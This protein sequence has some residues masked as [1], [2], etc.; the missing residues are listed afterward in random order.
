MPDSVLQSNTSSRGV[1]NNKWHD[2]RS[3]ENFVYIATENNELYHVDII[4]DCSD[5]V[6][7]FEESF[8][9]IGAGKKK[10]IIKSPSGKIE[11]VDIGGK[12][13]FLVDV[14]KY[15]PRTAF[16]NGLSGIYK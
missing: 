1:S 5:F 3:T 7:R 6:K 4:N 8:E 15:E 12:C 14:S 10:V 16:I 13:T 2:A 9:L 11:S